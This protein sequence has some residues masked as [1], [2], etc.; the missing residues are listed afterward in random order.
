VPVALA[1]DDEGVSRSNITQEY[2][3]VVET[4]HLSYADLKKIARASIAYS[5]LPAGDKKKAQSQ[6]DAAFA[7]FERQF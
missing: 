3:R 2:Q 6:L 1:T 7:K 4:Y 5:F